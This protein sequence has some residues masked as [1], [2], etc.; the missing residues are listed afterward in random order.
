MRW[1]YVWAEY[2]TDGSVCCSGYTTEDFL[3]QNLAEG[4]KIILYA[5]YIDADSDTSFGLSL[6]L[7]RKWYNWRKWRTSIRGDGKILYHLVIRMLWNFQKV[8]RCRGRPRSHWLRN[9]MAISNLLW[10]RRGPVRLVGT[11]TGK[12]GNC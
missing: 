2:E 4:I 10:T 9:M 5:K 12:R 11:T 6:K 7:A 1:L 8:R 3:I